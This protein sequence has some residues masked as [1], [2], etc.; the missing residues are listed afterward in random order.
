MGDI[1][2]KNC[3]IPL[4]MCLFFNSNI[5]ADGK[6]RGEFPIQVQ[7]LS[8]GNGS[9]PSVG[10]N[11]SDVIYVG[12]DLLSETKTAA[13]GSVTGSATFTTNLVTARFSTWDDSGFYLQAGAGSADWSMSIAGPG[14][15]GTTSMEYSNNM[16]VDFKW[17][18]SATMAG[19]GW[20]WIGDSG[21]SGGL[22]LQS[23][24]LGE[25]EI[26]VTDTEGE[27]SAS[28]I[29]EEEKQWKDLYGSWSSFANIYV[30][31]GWNF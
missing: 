20:N 19:L 18:S 29:A 8:G 24:S 13:S 28:E 9:G 3:L 17:P 23:I 25:P 21:F 26:T 1:T 11:I 14:Y 4:C 27:A 6:T 12:A 15:I 31:I 2:K 5:F 30:N 22:G 16:K 7:Y 10:Y